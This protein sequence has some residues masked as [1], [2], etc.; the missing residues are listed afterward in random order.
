MASRIKLAVIIVGA[1][2]A[3]AV[4]ATLLLVVVMPPRISVS[5]GDGVSEIR[6]DGEWLEINTSRWGAS[7]STVAVKEAKVAPD[8]TRENE[9]LL[10]GHLQDGRFVL[11]DGSN[12]LVS[13]A[14][15]TVTVT[16][17][18]KEFDLSGI[19]DLASEQTHTFTTVTTPMPMVPKDGLKVKYGEDLRVEWNIPVSNFEYQLEGIQSTSRLDEDGRVARIILAKFE[20]GKEYPLKITSAT[21]NNGRELKTPV[22]TKAA[23]AAALTATFDPA[24]GTFSASTEAYP[25]IIFSEPV[26]N[27]DQ[28]K[29]LVT[30]EPKVE[31]SLKWPEPNKLE[32]VPTAPW[33]HLQ[34]VTIH[35]KAGP[36]ALRGIGGGF[37]EADAS[38]TFTTAPAKSI[39]VNVTEQTVTLLENGTPVESFLCSS[40]AVGTDSPLGD[41][42]I[43]AKMA[44]IDMRGPGYF[45]PKVPWVMVFKGDYTMHGNYWATSFGRRSSHG[46]VGLPVETA[47]HVYDWTPIGTPIRIHE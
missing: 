10:S 21:S 38:S 44:S 22:I 14:E 3:L 4:M 42:T 25:T 17:T 6:P 11:E 31:G 40:G 35:L 7:L 9:R 45:A 16:G 29:T 19:N 37:V 47:K 15:Y 12:P 30:V 20:Q 43:Y 18:V 2:V 36:A 23:T 34:D 24:D 13:D 1:A 27:P 32:F 8:G 33:D 28:A 46:C 41:Y 26:S 5:P 39:D